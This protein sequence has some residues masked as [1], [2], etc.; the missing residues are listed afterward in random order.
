MID[1]LS[2]LLR[3]A[4]F[5]W[6]FQAGGGALFCLSHN[7]DGSLP[8]TAARIRRSALAAIGAVLAESLLTPARM[9]GELSG[10]LDPEMLQLAYL[11]GGGAA[12][13]LRVAGLV[14]LA[15]SAARPGRILR[16]PALL[17][18]LLT[19]VSFLLVGH[20]TTHAHRGVLASLLF[21]HL[22]GIAF[23][24][25]ALGPLIEVLKAEPAPRAAVIVTRF[26]MTATWV[27][28]VLFAA[29]LG[30]AV[31]L[32]PGVGALLTPYGTLLLTKLALFACL[33]LLAS[34]NKW[35]L[36][37]RV[38]QGDASAMTRLQRVIRV[39]QVL[40]IAVLLVTSFMTSWLSPQG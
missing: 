11:S 34:I 4:S 40:L 31:Q 37:P 33:L 25:G 15:V 7:L 9:A 10:V 13:G 23:W 12:C 2:V 5:V 1:V 24:L 28:P 21:I 8:G 35:R 16:L 32:L 26:S 29:A 36:A 19:L 39:E 30:I 27:V 3:A 14:M 17:G 20:T 38:A 6:L 18:T 22:L